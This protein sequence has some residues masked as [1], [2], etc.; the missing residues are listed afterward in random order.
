MSD[1]NDGI[2]AIHICENCGE[3]L[4][5]RY[6]RDPDTYYGP[7]VCGICGRGPTT[8]RYGAAEPIRAIENGIFEADMRG[9]IVGCEPI[10]DD[11][12]EDWEYKIEVKVETKTEKDE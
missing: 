2:V 7:P 12:D 3:L 8:R 10:R 4:R 5:S 9:L 11:D 6:P 1:D